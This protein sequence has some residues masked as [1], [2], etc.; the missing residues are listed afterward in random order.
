MRELANMPEVP[1]FGV[2]FYLDAHSGLNLPLIAELTLIY[3]HW[4]KW[5]VMIDDFEVPGSAYGYNDYGPAGALN[6]DLLGSLKFRNV[7]FY[8]PAIDAERESGGKRGCV[9][10]CE[11]EG[12]ADALSAVESLKRYSPSGR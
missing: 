2:F 9:V 3:D 11:D 1:K 10:M 7:Y 12:V 5:V 6:L 8:F 4:T